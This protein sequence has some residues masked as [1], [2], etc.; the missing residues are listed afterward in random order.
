MRGANI[1]HSLIRASGKP[2]GLN[3]DSNFPGVGNVVRCVRSEGPCFRTSRGRLEP[4]TEACQPQSIPALLFCSRLRVRQL[5]T[6]ALEL[7]APASTE[8]LL[9]VDWQTLMQSYKKALSESFSAA[10]R[11]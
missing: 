10:I 7:S 6:Q 8:P 1:R 9:I 5:L 3:S 2:R 4:I 11:P